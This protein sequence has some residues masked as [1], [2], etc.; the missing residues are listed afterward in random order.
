MRFVSLFVVLSL[1]SSLSFAGPAAVIS[2]VVA[3]SPCVPVVSHGVVV[4]PCPLYP[5]A[6]LTVPRRV[7]SADSLKSPRAAAFTRR[8]SVAAPVVPNSGA[9]NDEMSR[10]T[11]KKSER[12]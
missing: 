12:R 10:I 6:A 4:V 9:L 5:A 3:S 1:A 2:R 11:G 7:V 8:S